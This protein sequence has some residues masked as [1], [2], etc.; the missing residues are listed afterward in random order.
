MNTCTGWSSAVRLCYSLQ[1]ILLL[2]GIGVGGALRKRNRR[3]QNQLVLYTSKSWV[4][5]HCHLISFQEKL[6]IIYQ[7]YLGSIDELI[8]QALSNTLDVPERSFSRPC[9]GEEDDQIP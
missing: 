5:F 7:D 3:D 1:L 6:Y 4:E 8:C 2:D 9:V